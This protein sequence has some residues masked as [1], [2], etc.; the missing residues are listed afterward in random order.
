MANTP[1]PVAQECHSQAQCG[2]DWDRKHSVCTESAQ[3]GAASV[4]G[5]CTGPLIVLQ[6]CSS[7]EQNAFHF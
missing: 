7:W 2:Q 4:W 5:K 6:L 3:E 1:I